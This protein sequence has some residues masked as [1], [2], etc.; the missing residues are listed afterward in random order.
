MEYITIASIG[1]ATDFGD[2]GETVMGLA[3]YGNNTKWFKSGGSSNGSF[4]AYSNRIDTV[5][6]AT[7]GNSSDYGDLNTA[8]NRAAGFSSTTR[9]ITAGGYISPG[10]FIGEIQQNDLSSGATGTDFGDLTVARAGAA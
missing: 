10:S 6:I 9:G 2:L 5:T 7:T 8:L 1:N 4:T 3:G